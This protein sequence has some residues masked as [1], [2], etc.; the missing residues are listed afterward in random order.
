MPTKSRPPLNNPETL[1]VASI[2]LAVKLLYPFD[3]RQAPPTSD[4]D[5]P[6]LQ[7]DWGEWQKIHSEHR[8]QS[9]PSRAF[10]LLT[11]EDVMSMTGEEM[12]EYLE[13]FE[14]TRLPPKEGEIKFYIPSLSDSFFFPTI[15]A[16]PLLGL[17]K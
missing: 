15:I 11:S 1:L 8:P 5:L 13:W 17:T 16:I 14:Q 9:P 6:F 2:V 3:G 7:V 10:D 4:D 12:D